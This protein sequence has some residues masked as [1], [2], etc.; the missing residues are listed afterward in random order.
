MQRRIRNSTFLFWFLPSAWKAKGNL[1]SFSSSFWRLFTFCLCFCL[2]HIIIKSFFQIF[3]NFGYIENFQNFKILGKKSSK[4][5]KFKNIVNSY[6]LKK[7]YAPSLLLLRKPFVKLW[8]T[9]FVQ[10]KRWLFCK[11]KDP[12]HFHSK[13]PYL[14][15]T[16]KYLSKIQICCHR[17]RN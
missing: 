14:Y 6:L 5:W 4:P 13:L 2:L 3:Y 8:F 17:F 1:V 7:N 11:L 16:S 12:F 15:A 9:C 10:V